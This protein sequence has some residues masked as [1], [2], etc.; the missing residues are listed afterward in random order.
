LSLIEDEY[1]QK[2][3]KDRTH[4]DVKFMIVNSLNN[5]LWLIEKAPGFGHLHALS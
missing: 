4:N 1:K 3:L 5:I 2:A